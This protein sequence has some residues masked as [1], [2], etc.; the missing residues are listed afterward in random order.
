MNEKNIIPQNDSVL[1]KCISEKEKTIKG[2]SFKYES[3]DLLE[4]KVIA[5]GPK[6]SESVIDLHE[7]DV[8]ISNSTGTLIKCNDESYYAFKLENI[9]AKISQ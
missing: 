5:I 1:C 6:A 8:I 7:G 2:T 4:Y 9:V 3:N